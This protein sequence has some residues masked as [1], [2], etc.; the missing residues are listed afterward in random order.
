MLVTFVGAVRLKELAVHLSDAERQFENTVH[1]FCV[2]APCGEGRVNPTHF[3][4]LWSPF[5]REFQRLWSIEM[6]NRAMAR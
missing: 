4:G 1:Y 3:F 2:E 6:K 5:L